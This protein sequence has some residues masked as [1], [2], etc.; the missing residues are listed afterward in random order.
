[1]KNTTLAAFGAA[2]LLIGS[3]LGAQAMPFGA[4]SGASPLVDQVA[5]GCGPGYA[6]GPYGGCRP[7]GYRPPVYVA[8]RPVIV[9]PRPVVVAPRVYRRPVVVRPYRRW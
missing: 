7:M 4:A 2:A 6:R 9:A 3:A 1:M 8:P 5:Q